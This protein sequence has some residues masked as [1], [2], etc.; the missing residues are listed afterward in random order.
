MFSETF[1]FV[2]TLYSRAACP[3]STVH[4]TTLQ[5]ITITSRKATRSDSDQ[6]NQA[7]II[8]TSS[9]LPSSPKPLPPEPHSLSPQSQPSV[10]AT[11]LARKRST[12]TVPATKEVSPPLRGSSRPSP[13]RLPYLPHSPFHLFSYDLDE[14]TA[15]S[16]QAKRS[17]ES[18]KA[19]PPRSDGEQSSSRL[20]ASSSSFLTITFFAL[21]FL[22]FVFLFFPPTWISFSTTFLAHHLL[23]FTSSFHFLPFTA[24]HPGSNPLIISPSSCSS[25]YFSL[26]LLD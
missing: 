9:S 11:L 4:R 20:P 8:Q 16:A 1:P 24:L 2:V 7:E 14:D 3:T 21:P 12:V 5:S 6:K 22:V 15:Q 13:D 10:L 19:T 18:P 25:P 17:E 23:F 26:A